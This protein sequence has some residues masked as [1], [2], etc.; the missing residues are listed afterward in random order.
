MS[1]SD[2]W[3][4]CDWPCPH[5][6][7]T[8]EYWYFAPDCRGNDLSGGVQCKSCGKKFDSRTKPKKAS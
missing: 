2:G 5:C 3:G 7:G 8:V 4:N 1:A 6:G